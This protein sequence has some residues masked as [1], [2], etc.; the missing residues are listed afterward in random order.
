M[1]RLAIE[2][3]V[4]CEIEWLIARRVSVDVDVGW[5]STEPFQIRDHTGRRQG[6]HAI[7]DEDLVSY[8]PFECFALLHEVRVG[9]QGEEWVCDE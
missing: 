7:F 2:G 8:F 3:L 6:R 5:V 9:K 4:P 1:D